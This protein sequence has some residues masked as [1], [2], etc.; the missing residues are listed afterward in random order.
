MFAVNNLVLERNRKIINKEEV[1]ESNGMMHKVTYL[2]NSLYQLDDNE[3]PI[4][5]EELLSLKKQSKKLTSEELTEWIE[6]I[7]KKGSGIIQSFANTG[8]VV[9]M[10]E[11]D[12]SEPLDPNKETQEIAKHLDEYKDFITQYIYPDTEID[13]LVVTL[14]QDLKKEEVSNEDEK[15]QNSLK[16]SLKNKI[17]NKNWR[18]IFFG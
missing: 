5:R 4:D 7:D 1:L 3:I 2:G 15:R 13:D 10:Y 8:V 16:S 6:E 18:N 17:N 11:V 12:H 14:R 9:N